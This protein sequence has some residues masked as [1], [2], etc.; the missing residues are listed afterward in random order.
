MF[1]VIGCPGTTFPWAHKAGQH[2]SFSRSNQKL[3]VSM[4][5]GSQPLEDMQCVCMLG[6]SE[7]KI[8]TNYS[9]VKRSLGASR[10]FL[11]G[12]NLQHWQNPLIWVFATMASHPDLATDHRWWGSAYT[13]LTKSGWKAH[14]SEF[15]MQKR[16]ATDINEK[17]TKR[18]CLIQTL[19]PQILSWE[20]QHS[21]KY[22]LTVALHPDLKSQ[23]DRCRGTPEMLSY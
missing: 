16:I 17:G 4:I 1:L 8:D 6:S 9:S 21:Q 15:R 18:D 13:C 10:N 7:L 2:L 14:S 5:Q 23:N 20:S 12:S 22:N 11:V 3:L 19:P